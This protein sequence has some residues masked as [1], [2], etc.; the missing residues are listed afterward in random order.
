[1]NSYNHLDLMPETIIKKQKYVLQETGGQENRYIL[2]GGR[3]LNMDEQLENRLLRNLRAHKVR[4]GICSDITGCKS[5]MWNCLDCKFFVPDADQ[6]D[7]YKEQAA[8]WRDKSVRFSDFPIIKGNAERN[9]GLY[10]HIMKK[11]KEDE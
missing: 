8:L 5:D 4:G 9:A 11:L 6:L 3:I 2:F 7:Y 1:M 10:E